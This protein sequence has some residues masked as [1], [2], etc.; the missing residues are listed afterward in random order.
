[1]GSGGSSR[2]HYMEEPFWKR[3]WTC[4]QTEYWMNEWMGSVYLDNINQPPLRYHSFVD[5]H[6]CCWTISV[7]TH[8]VSVLQQLP[9]LCWPQSSLSRT[10]YGHSTP[11][12]QSEQSTHVCYRVHMAAESFATFWFRK[13]TGVTWGGR[14]ANG[15]PPQIFFLPQNRF[16]GQLVEDAQ[17]KNGVRV[18]GKWCMYI[19]GW[20][21]SSPPPPTFLNRLSQIQVSNTHRRFR[22]PPSYDISTDTSMREHR[23]TVHVRFA[24]SDTIGVS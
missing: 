10:I 24:I 22:P 21:K 3:R 11:S 15:P 20:F 14:G 8:H 16:L 9:L 18:R 13:Y 7:F 17:I 23:W 5:L 1:M 12:T 6:Y 2:S 4:R 19:K